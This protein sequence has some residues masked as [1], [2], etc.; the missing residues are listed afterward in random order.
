M[1]AT[2]KSQIQIKKGDSS[3]IVPISNDKLGLGNGK[4]KR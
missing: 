2:P 4:H 1:F 3:E